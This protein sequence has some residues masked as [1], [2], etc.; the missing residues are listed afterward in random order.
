MNRDANS[1]D[2]M[3]TGAVEHPGLDIPISSDVARE[4]ERAESLFAEAVKSHVVSKKEYNQAETDLRAELLEVQT[5]LRD[6]DF[7][8]LVL[9]AGVDGGGKGELANL[10]NYWMDPRGIV[11]R[12]YGDESEEEAERPRYWRYWRDLPERGQ[13][14]VFLSAW[15]SRPL[16]DRVYGESTPEQFETQLEMIRALER[17]LAED[18]TLILKFWMHLGL[19]DQKRR[20]ETLEADPLNRWRVTRK[21]WEHWTMYDR[22]VRTGARIIEGTG[23]EVAPWNIVDGSD[24]RFR[25]LSVGRMIRDALET[26]LDAMDARRQA[27]GETDVA[28]ETSAAEAEASAIAVTGANRPVRVV[29]VLSGLDL[30]RSLDK[31]DYR[32]EL[33]R[34]QARLNR[35]HRLARDRGRSTIL[36]FEGWDA[37]GKG[38]A[39][40]RIVPALDMRDVRVISIAVPTDE[41]YEHHYMWRFWR[42]L[43][44]AG[45]VT[46]FDRSWY[47]RVLVERIEGF[48]TPDEWMRAYQEINEFETALVDHGI[49]LAKFWVHISQDEQDRRFRAREEVPYKR[50]KLTEEDW[51]NRRQWSAYEEAVDDMVRLTS[52]PYAPWILVEGN[53]KRFARVKVLRSV[54]DVL[55]DALGVPRETDPIRMAGSSSSP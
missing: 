36:V 1:D 44:R 15:Y 16:L 26:R 45:K 28:A 53:D 47:G 17:T 24:W 11:T 43:S 25:S 6:A 22:F 30:Q 19:E 31:K 54:C 4:V 33:K 7:N 38:G 29:S 50:W 49:V 5:R 8:V 23:T 35:L 51:R 21:D 27:D 48:A 2:S 3:W 34:L 20:L 10:M 46:I 14:G 13:I 18:G 39:I 9:F 52:K 42:H 41:E 55:S 32:A 12:A 40:R 37:A